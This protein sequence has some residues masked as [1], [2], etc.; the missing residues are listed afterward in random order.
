M[1]TFSWTW[2]FDDLSFAHGVCALALGLSVLAI[3][4][5]VVQ[6]MSSPQPLP[7]YLSRRVFAAHLFA[8]LFLELGKALVWHELS[9]WT[10]ALHVL[11]FGLCERGQPLLTRLLHGPSFGGSH[12]I[13]VTYL[14]SML[15]ERST[16]GGLS[17]LQMAWSFWLHTVPCALHWADGLLNFKD[18]Q[19]AYSPPMAGGVTSIWDAGGLVPALRFAGARTTLRVWSAAAGYMM[20][21]LLWGRT[22]MQ[23]QAFLS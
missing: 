3:V 4:L 23:K 20:L 1:E 6:R 12:A 11:Y 5:L 15:T 18:L 2:I 7:I 13:L 22:T 10:M 8:C 9:T 16:S 19:A 14:F 17:I 21:G